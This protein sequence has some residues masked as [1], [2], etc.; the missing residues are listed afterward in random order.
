MRQAVSRLSET[1]Q[2]VLVDGNLMIPRLKIQ[3]KAIVGGDG[4]VLPIACASIIAK[5]TRDRI[6]NKY[7]RQYP[8]YGFDRHKGY[9]TEEHRN[10]I[11]QLG[12]LEI[13]RKSFRLLDP[14]FALDLEAAEESS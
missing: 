5:V 8:G 12:P 11:A 6:M 2:A 7:H 10:R 3:Q 1:P 4:T 9:P 13:H 14:Q